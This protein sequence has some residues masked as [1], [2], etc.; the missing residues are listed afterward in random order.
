MPF[1][2]ELRL[3]SR[4]FASCF[5]RAFSLDFAADGVNEARLLLFADMTLNGEA[6]FYCHACLYLARAALFMPTA[7]S[8]H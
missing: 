4:Y 5:R 7:D 1:S 8:C 3:L 2:S 6:S